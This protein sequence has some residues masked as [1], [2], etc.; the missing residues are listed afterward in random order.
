M[1]EEKNPIKI[2]VEELIKEA[3]IVLPEEEM[4]VYKTKI[5][6]Q[7]TRRIGLASLNWLDAQGLDDYE[8]MIDKNPS[9]EQVQDFFTSRVEN[10]QAKIGEVFEEFSRDFFAS[11]GRK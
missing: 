10:Y 2:F 6:D 5:E 9:P 8:K 3:N 4:E 7:L 11:L 1:P